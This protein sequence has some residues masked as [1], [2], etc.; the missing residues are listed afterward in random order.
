MGSGGAR[1][2]IKDKRC[3]PP[4]LGYLENQRL[5]RLPQFGG[6]HLFFVLLRGL[7]C[8][9]DLLDPLVNLPH[10]LVE[11]GLRLGLAGWD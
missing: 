10:V 8:S 7:G 1:K 9:L 2:S 5:P 6:W 4:N 11:P 3:Q